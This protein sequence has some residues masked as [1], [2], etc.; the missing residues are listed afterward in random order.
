MDLRDQGGTYVLTVSV[1]QVGA[2]PSTH[3]KA[4]QIFI[5]NSATDSNEGSRSGFHQTHQTAGDL[6]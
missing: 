4:N 1:K 6:V 2:K 5:M 3:L